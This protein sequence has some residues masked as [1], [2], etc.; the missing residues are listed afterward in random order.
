MT[1]LL[2]DSNRD[3][4]KESIETPPLSRRE[5]A[6][7]PQPT[8]TPIS[9][10]SNTRD[11]TVPSTAS[12][13]KSMSME[14]MYAHQTDITSTLQRFHSIDPTTLSTPSNS[15]SS[16]SPSSVS[17][18]QPNGDI[19][20][21]NNISPHT[22][23][24]L[25]SY[26]SSSP[27]LVDDTTNSLEFARKDSSTDRMQD[28]SLDQFAGAIDVD[29]ADHC[30]R[31]AA[32][33]R[34][35]RRLGFS[36]FVD[37]L[38]HPDNHVLRHLNLS[39]ANVPL[40][41]KTLRLTQLLHSHPLFRTLT[42][43]IMRSVFAEFIQQVESGDS[44]LFSMGDHIDT[45]YLIDAGEIE[46]TYEQDGISTVIKKYAG[47][48]IND[49]SLMQPCV[50]PQ[51]F[52][53]RV[54][55]STASLYSIDGCIFRFIIQNGM[56]LRY[57]QLKTFFQSLTLFDHLPYSPMFQNDLLENLIEHAQILEFHE[58]DVIIPTV[59]SSPSSSPPSSHVSKD[60]NLTL[61]TVRFDGGASS[62]V[63]TTFLIPSALSTSLPYSIPSLIPSSESSSCASSAKTQIRTLTLP[64]SVESLPTQSLP[65]YLGSSVFIVKDGLVTNLHP[66]YVSS[67][68]SSTSSEASLP[69]FPADTSFICSSSSSTSTSTSPSPPVSLDHIG[70]GGMFGLE[71]L[72][73]P[74]RLLDHS[75]DPTLNS[76]LL[77]SSVGTVTPIMSTSFNLSSH[78]VGD[79]SAPGTASASPSR[80]RSG[81]RKRRRSESEGEEDYDHINS[82]QVDS[83][84]NSHSRQSIEET[85]PS[86]PL[87][88]LPSQSIAPSHSPSHSTSISSSIPSTCLSSPTLSSLAF[89]RLVR[90]CHCRGEVRCKSKAAVIIAIEAKIWKSIL[91]KAI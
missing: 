37:P 54:V 74:H 62:D 52:S 73:C 11:Y 8:Q 58:G 4:R 64:T 82:D 28:S 7:N 72:S 10:L 53:V 1:I 26:D 2:H 35:K 66:T 38:D 50:V 61:P 46:C 70:E 63:P 13:D 59:P 83:I 90:S 15:S 31:I 9:A 22:H 60:A 41:D 48:T 39:A 23:H 67:P 19:H 43:D 12:V 89:D 14:Y 3:S 24:I 27:P 42:P 32:N 86:F 29:D 57:T 40:R 21:H 20:H 5:L 33:Q 76:P 18:V 47:D 56:Q 55:S 87:T 16:S 80:S 44:I 85:N 81:N 65:A 71:I 25:H 49:L 68:S 69:P 79:G 36:V 88:S 34:K 77:V 51:P 91:L 30:R 45:F 78:Q 17:P 84:T 6:P 75:I